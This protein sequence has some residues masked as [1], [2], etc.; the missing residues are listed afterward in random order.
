VNAS[1]GSEEDEALAELEVGVELC[2]SRRRPEVENEGDEFEGKSRKALRRVPGD[3]WAAGECS[4][5]SN[6]DD[7]GYAPAAR[8]GWRAGHGATDQ[9]DEGECESR[10]EWEHLKGV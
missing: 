6:K 3:D 4:A 7:E 1:A 10:E 2:G 5:R 9:V 8:A